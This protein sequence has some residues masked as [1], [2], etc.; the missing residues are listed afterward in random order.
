[1]L[2]IGKHV[3]EWVAKC[4]NEFGHFGTDVGIGWMRD[5]QIVAGVAYAD[6][7][8]PNIVC[9]IASDGSRR[10]LTRE[11]LWTIFDYPFNQCGC[12]RITVCVGQGNKDSVRFVKHLGFSPETTL[13]G[14]HP[15]GDL[16]VLVMWK[17]SC[18]WISQDFVK[19]YAKAA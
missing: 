11:Y 17:E 12:K 8:G 19:P 14:A 9:H 16:L 13:R 6:W 4:T 1:M 10:W 7:N 15:T 2:T 18:R 5:G 3:V